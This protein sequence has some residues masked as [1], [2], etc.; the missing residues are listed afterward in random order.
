MSPVEETIP[1]SNDNKIEEVI[2]RLGGNRFVKL[3][4]KGGLVGLEV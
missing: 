3:S 4:R 2:L 1:V